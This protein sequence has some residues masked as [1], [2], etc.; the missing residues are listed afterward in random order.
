MTCT[1]AASPSVDSIL[2]FGYMQS[3]V[4]R[5][6]DVRV[7]EWFCV[8]A[9]LNAHADFTAYGHFESLMHYTRQN[10]ILLHFILFY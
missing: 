4:I 7:W 3:T 1:W 8:F 9:R 10:S 6:L 2:W 5:P